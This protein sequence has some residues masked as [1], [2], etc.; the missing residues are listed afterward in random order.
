MGSDDHKLLLVRTTDITQCWS[1]FGAKASIKSVSIRLGLE[2]SQYLIGAASCDGNVRVWKVA[3]DGDGCIVSPLCCRECL[4]TERHVGMLGKPRH[5]VA[6]CPLPSTSPP[7]LAVPADNKVMFL[8]PSDSDMGR[9][10]YLQA[11]KVAPATLDVVVVPLG[12]CAWS[13]DAH[14]LVT[15]DTATTV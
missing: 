13:P 12:T 3:G 10:A 15:A 6:W 5:D 2:P 1:L 11:W 14:W 9:K 7:R 4:G 8:C